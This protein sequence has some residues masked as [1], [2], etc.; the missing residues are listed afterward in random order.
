MEINL[1]SECTPFNY[2]VRAVVPV[3]KF[4]ETYNMLRFHLQRSVAEPKMSS[5]KKHES[6]YRKTLGI[7]DLICIYNK[8]FNLG[9]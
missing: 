8:V 9:I 6:S 4:Y 3:C 2:I 7:A 1:C 5:Y